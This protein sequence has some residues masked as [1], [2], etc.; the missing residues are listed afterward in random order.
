MGTDRRRS[1][2]VVRPETTRSHL[3]APAAFETNQKFAWKKRRELEDGSGNTPSYCWV[4]LL[5]GDDYVFNAAQDLSQRFSVQRRQIR[6]ALSVIGRFLG[7][8]LYI[9]IE[10]FSISV[11]LCKYTEYE[12][13][14]VRRAGEGRPAKTVRQ[15]LA[16]KNLQQERASEEGSIAGRPHGGCFGGAELVSSGAYADSLRFHLVMVRRLIGLRRRLV[17]GEDSAIRVLTFVNFYIDVVLAYLHLVAVAKCISESPI[18][19][20]PSDNSKNSP[21]ISRLVVMGVPSS[22]SRPECD[23][24]MAKSP[25]MRSDGVFDESEIDW[26]HHRQTDGQTDR[27]ALTV[28]LLIHR[29]YSLRRRRRNRTANASTQH[30]SPDV[31]V[32]NYDDRCPS[33]PPSLSPSADINT[34]V[35]QKPLRLLEFNGRLWSAVVTNVGKR[36]RRVAWT[37]VAA[38]HVNDNYGRAS[39]GRR[40]PDGTQIRS[41]DRP[42]MTPVASAVSRSRPERRQSRPGPAQRPPPIGRPRGSSTS[43]YLGK[44]PAPPP[45]DVMFNVFTVA[46]K[47]AFVWCTAPVVYQ[48]RRVVPAIKMHT[49]RRTHRD[50]IDRRLFFLLEA[51]AMMDRRPGSSREPIRSSAV[52]RVMND[53]CIR[54]DGN[55]PDRHFCFGG[56]SWTRRRWATG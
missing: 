9:A 39:G 50:A 29:I 33:S 13:A 26:D 20:C 4:P 22:S 52:Y 53:G 2:D 47:P 27:Y 38:V 28:R 3:G 43:S 11:V 10:A 56:G 55:R 31:I 1:V 32:K 51:T 37:A 45:G 7:D 41:I 35:G 19:V 49:D 24:D 40:R 17:W 16:G 46:K 48:R 36:R 34:G 30:P 14:G 15:K 12:G 5:K 21:V 8:A 25:P 42:A 23:A 6:P 54:N 18:H 44:S